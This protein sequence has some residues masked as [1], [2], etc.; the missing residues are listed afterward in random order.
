MMDFEVKAVFKSITVKFHESGVPFVFKRDIKAP[1]FESVNKVFVIVGPRRAGKTF[2]LFQVMQELLNRGNLITDFLYVNFEDERISEI[3]QTQ[4]GLLLD[5]YGE[6]YPGKKPVVF[7]DEVQNVA[8]WEKFARRLNDG[9]YKVYVTGSNSKLLSR[10]IATS[11]RGRSFSIQVLPLSF[12][13]FLKFNAVELTSNWEFSSTAHLVKKLFDE[14]IALSGFPEIVLEK[15]LE[16]I[17]EYFKTMLHYDLIERFKIKNSDLLRL[18]MK[19]ST[20]MYACEFSINKFN[21]FAKSSGYSSST[22]VVHK[23][24]KILEEA[25]FYYLVAAR[26]KSFKKESSYLKKLYL[27]DLSLANFYNTEK[28]SGRLLENAVFLELM[29][30]NVSVNYYKNGFEC[31]F[32]TEDSCIQVCYSLNENNKKREL[33][34]LLEAKKKFGSKNALLLTYDQEMEV[35]GIKTTPVWKWLLKK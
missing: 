21:N 35:Q 20:Q 19:Y 32:V 8:G 31:D 29:H 12:K 28:D 25:Y 1:F 13:E 3:K 11:L 7:L 16:F 30:R 2:L 22:S 33:T 34:G 9:R 6:L 18:L 10:E 26:Q 27:V 4:L 14:Y 5:A 24:S 15:K 23:Y 17:D